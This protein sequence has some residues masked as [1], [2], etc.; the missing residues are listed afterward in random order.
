MDQAIRSDD[1]S[2]CAAMKRKR[3]SYRGT[4]GK[5]LAKALVMDEPSIFARTEIRSETAKSSARAAAS[6]VAEQ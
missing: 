6:P 5:P 4:A 1:S 2:L 3:G